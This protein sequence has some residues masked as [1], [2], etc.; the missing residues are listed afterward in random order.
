[1]E[2]RR[3]NPFGH[4]FLL[5]A[6][7]LGGFAAGESAVAATGAASAPANIVIADQFGPGH[8][9]SVVIKRRG[10]LEKRFPNTRFEWKIVTS[11]AVMRDGML[12]DD[13][14]IGI[15]APPPFLVGLDK[16]V[17][18]KI[19]A[20]AAT[21]DQW[22]VTKDPGV[23][24]IRDFKGGVKRQIALVGLDSFPAIVV[25]KAAQREFGDPRALDSDMVIMRPPDAVAAV[26]G[27]QLAGALIPPV[28]SVRAV[29]GGARVVLRSI[30]V[31]GGPVTNNFYVM[32]DEFYRRHP[33]VARAFHDAV[34]EAVRFIRSAPDEAFA[35][36]SEDEGGKTPPGKY[37]DLIERSG[38]EYGVIPHRVLEVATFMKQ[39]GM[40]GRAPRSMQEIE[41]PPLKGAGS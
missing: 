39:I 33:E 34:V 26:L 17:K 23:K 25:R 7:L 4:W 38:T 3:R 1:M 36:L 13:I 37:R 20:G 24:G 12:T 41:F 30:D 15:T 35:M 2:T 5:A 29:D 32:T 18:W 27:G 11:G 8:L 40:I 14:Q 16:G 9:V 22:L 10:L 19:I 21:Y 31:F 6:T 28:F